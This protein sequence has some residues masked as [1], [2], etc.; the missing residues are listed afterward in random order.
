MSSLWI[1]DQCWNCECD[2]C[3]CFLGFGGGIEKVV[4]VKELVDDGFE[5]L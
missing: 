3:W 2:E 1:M 5:L 4:F